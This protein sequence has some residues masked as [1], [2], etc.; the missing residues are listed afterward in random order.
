MMRSLR[1]AMG[2][3]ATPLAV[4]SA[5]T[6][7]AAD[8]THCAGPTDSQQPRT[9]FENMA[10]DGVHFDA[11]TSLRLVDDMGSVSQNR[12][13][14][15]FCRLSGYSFGLA[16]GPGG[17]LTFT[18]GEPLDVARADPHRAA[19]ALVGFE[20]QKRFAATRVIHPLLSVGAGSM[21]A[22]WQY[23]YGTPPAGST[24]PNVDFRSSTA[25]G[26][27]GAGFELN[28]FKYARADLMTGARFTGPLSTPGLAARPLQG[29]FV[30]GSIGIGK[31]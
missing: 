3:L 24:R 12:L 22:G 1:F 6:T 13:M 14:I 11:S 17:G 29:P 8:S 31:F 2:L 5:G 10:I 15:S 27:V 4:L 25:Y 20:I 23:A 28:L 16:W 26:A 9:L 19:I 21:V 30:S 7:V 18:T